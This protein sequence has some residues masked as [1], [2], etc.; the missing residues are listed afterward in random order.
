MCAFR[1]LSV[2]TSN[3]FTTLFGRV[4]FWCVTIFGLSRLWWGVHIGRSE[5]FELVTK[6]WILF[7]DILLFYSRGMLLNV[8][9]AKMSDAT[10]H[11]LYEH[12]TKMLI[13]CMFQL[14][15]K[16]SGEFWRP[17]DGAQRFVCRNCALM[18]FALAPVLN[19]SCSWRVH[20][21]LFCVTKQLDGCFLS[22]LSQ[23]IILFERRRWLPDLSVKG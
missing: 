23:I 17:N 18:G 8:Y 7:W 2:A 3:S 19:W 10:R 21:G 6:L 20:A 12:K 14:F 5:Q 4:F 15:P 13:A 9:C 16:S 1:A 11:Q 22:F